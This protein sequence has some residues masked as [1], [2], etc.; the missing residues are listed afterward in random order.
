MFINNINPILF[1]IGPFGV[2]FYG[3]VYALGFLAAYLFLRYHSKKGSLKLTEEQL[4]SF[5]LWLMIVSIFMARVFE[6]F[7]YNF[8]EYSGNLLEFFYIWHGGMAFQGGI[9]GAVLVTIFFCRKYRIRFYDLADLLVIPAALA[10]FFGKVAN[11]TNSE[12]YGRITNPVNTPW[13]V[14]FVK[15]DSYCRHPAQIYEAISIL[16]L[17]GILLWIY[18]YQRK[19]KKHHAGILFWTFI[20]LYGLLRFLLTFLRDEPLYLG[21][22]VG[23]WISLAMIIIAGLFL[24]KY[25]PKNI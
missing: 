11:Y 7:V 19:H 24:W 3:L 10:L 13:C 2:R 21:L 15:V 18:L 8:P 6:V 5:F 9:V 25:K 22:N 23:Q 16:L 12:L 17:F 20:G 1:S 14:V 4:D